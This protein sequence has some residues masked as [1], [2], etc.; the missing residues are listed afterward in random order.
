MM[1]LAPWRR[2][3]TERA[4]PTSGQS[5]GM[6]PAAVHHE[7]REHGVENPK[8][9]NVGIDLGTSRTAIAGDNGVRTCVPSYVGFARDPVS[10][11]M[12]GRDLLFGEEALR[13]RMALDLVRPMRQG[14]IDGSDAP[15]SN[16]ESYQKALHAAR[17][18]LR[19]M[20]YLLTSGEMKDVTIRGVVGAPALAS[21]RN[22]QALLDM[23]RG[24]LDD[25]MIVSEPFSVAYG[26]NMLNNALIID[27]GA[28]TVDL[29]RM[30]GT[31]PSEA[32]QIT[33]FK[34]GDHIDEVFL[35][36][37]TKKYRN[38]DLTVNMIKRF[39]EENAFVSDHGEGI[40][41]D[42]PVEGKPIRHDVTSELK[43]ACRSIIPDMVEAVRKLVAS[44]DPEFQNELKGNIILAGGG[45]QISGLRREIEKYMNKTLGYGRVVAVEEPMY[46][47]AN[48]ALL[49]CKDMPDEYWDELRSHKKAAGSVAPS[50]SQEG[51]EDGE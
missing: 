46:G 51:G 38:V 31:I 29:C 25:V 13:N 37:V 9:I 30:H 17:E 27:I 19:H 36:L 11:K 7:E 48:G 49:L 3:V 8:V 6:A 10:K 1:K 24:I 23:A 34:A 18:L 20:V 15:E 32:D 4:V 21:K 2:S 26:L 40:S 43:E 12:L 35:N 50:A 44:Y 14:V 16:V 33:T 39:K 28:G 42:L 45:S 22:K 47:G 41:I 5:V